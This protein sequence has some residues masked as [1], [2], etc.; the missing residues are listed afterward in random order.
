MDLFR[1]RDKIIEATNAS[2]IKHKKL[3]GLPSSDRLCIISWDGH[4]LTEPLSKTGY[5][6]SVHCYSGVEEALYCNKQANTN[7]KVSY[8]KADFVSRPRKNRSM[9]FMLLDMVSEANSVARMEFLAK[10]ASGHML[11]WIRKHELKDIKRLLS[12]NQVPAHGILAT[13]E[14]AILVAAKFKGGLSNGR[15]DSI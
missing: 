11:V 15:G 10:L 1:G 7:K 14:D 8:H 6:E 4:D 9:S 3:L 5:W 12:D 13:E 2:V